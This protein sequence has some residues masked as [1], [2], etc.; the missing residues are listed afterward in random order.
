MELPIEFQLLDYKIPRPWLCYYMVITKERPPIVIE[1][2]YFF[3]FSQV[4]LDIIRPSK[5]SLVKS[6]LQKVNLGEVCTQKV[7]EK[8]KKHSYSYTRG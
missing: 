1:S 3:E 7:R 6:K 5:P 8:F 4:F 2:E